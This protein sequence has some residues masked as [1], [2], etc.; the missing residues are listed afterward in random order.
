[1]ANPVQLPH[2][3][4]GFEPDGVP[5]SMISVGGD[6]Y[7]IEPNQDQMLKV[8]TSGTVS[9]VI[10]ISAKL[11]KHITPTVV[12][13]RGGAIFMLAIWVCFQSFRGVLVFTRLPLAAK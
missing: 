11:N 4:G 6:L 7:V 10:D 5:Y 1:M 13:S 3:G 2:E 8:T 12:A 9:R